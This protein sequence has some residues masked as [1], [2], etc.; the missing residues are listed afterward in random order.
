VFH[1]VH[2]GVSGISYG[3]VLDEALC[4]G[5]IDSLVRR[6]DEDRYVRKLTPRKPKS[7]WS[8]IN[9]RKWKQLKATGR[10]APPG[11]AA[12]PT[13]ARDDWPPAAPDE[14]PAYIRQALEAKPVAWRFFQSLPPG[15]RRY[16]VLWIDAAKRAETRKRRLAEALTLLAGKRRLGLK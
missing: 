2:T 10:L 16:Y 6:L 11:L 9:R 8:D 14:V 13:P 15:Q 12:A 4:F 3:D 5:W 1:K 7:V